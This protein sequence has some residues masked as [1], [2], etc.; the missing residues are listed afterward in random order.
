MY[1]AARESADLGITLYVTV[2]VYVY[3]RVHGMKGQVD[4]QWWLL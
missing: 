4:T 1:V 2:T 3:M